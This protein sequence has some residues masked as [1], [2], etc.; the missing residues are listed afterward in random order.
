M[1]KSFSKEKYLVKNKT[2]F[3]CLTADLYRTLKDNTKHLVL[4]Y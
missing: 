4:T 2:I 3:K 1:G